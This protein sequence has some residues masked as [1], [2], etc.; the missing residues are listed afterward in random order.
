MI[1]GEA[2]AMHIYQVWD[3]WD[4]GDFAGVL[5]IGDSWFWYPEFNLLH[6][7][8]NNRQ[9]S[10]DYKTVQVLGFNGA[11]LEEY[12][13]PGR[14]AKDMTYHLSFANRHFFKLFLIS[15]AGNDA[16]NY[17]L[18]LK[19]DCS[20]I[21]Q[22]ADCFDAAG[23][24]QLLGITSKAMRTLVQ[25]IR[26]SY[27]DESP[28]ERPI[29]INGY[30]RPVPDGRGFQPHGHVTVTGPWLRPALD[31]AHVKPDLQFRIEVMS[32]FLGRLNATFQQLHNPANGVIFISSMGTLSVGGDYR[33][34]WANEIHPTASG[35]DMIVQRHWMPELQRLGMARA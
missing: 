2:E 9:L 1:S 28:T 24:D 26:A 34:D 12:N 5:A 6:S 25:Q 15:G 14:Y 10:D 21:G 19:P 23:L 22:P 27:P 35:F 29:L 11:R 33:R 32:F 4:P 30:D 13:P 7:L 8:C 18:A 31:A 16:V 20:A 3:H 17:R